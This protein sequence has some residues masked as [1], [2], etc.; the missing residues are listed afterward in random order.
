MGSSLFLGHEDASAAAA[1]TDTSVQEQFASD[2]GVQLPGLDSDGGSCTCDIPKLSMKELHAEDVKHLKSLD[3]WSLQALVR[4]K[5]SGDEAFDKSVRHFEDAKSNIDKALA[6]L[7]QEYT[8]FALS[9]RDLE[10]EQFGAALIHLS[11]C[12]PLR[13]KYGLELDCR[14]S[15]HKGLSAYRAEQHP[16]SCVVGASLPL[17]PAA[18]PCFVAA[19]DFSAAVSGIASVSPHAFNW[20]SRHRGANFL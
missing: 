15:F 1:A 10:Q 11:R 13:D 12:K 9:R 17:R 5:P 7:R 3:N 6:H 14:R 20:R 4:R 2:S 18:A 19:A 8:K 16:P